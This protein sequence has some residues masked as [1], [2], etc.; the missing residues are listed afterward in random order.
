MGK[1]RFE[2]VPARA[3]WERTCFPRERISQSWVFILSSHGRSLVS[4]I[5]NTEKY[6]FQTFHT[7]LTMLA[8]Q[9]FCLSACPFS[10]TNPRTTTQ[11]EG[12]HVF[13]EIPQSPYAGLFRQN[14]DKNLVRKS[15][16]HILCGGRSARQF[17]NNGGNLLENFQCDLFLS[18]HHGGLVPTLV[19]CVRQTSSFPG[20]IPI[21]PYSSSMDIIPICVFVRVVQ[22]R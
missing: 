17:H 3:G 5:R 22:D 13:R 18:L 20:L 16:C 8:G 7:Q 19:E 10:K 21:N 11:R 14:R 2:N 12:D 15:K 1:E 6:L 9:V 4:E